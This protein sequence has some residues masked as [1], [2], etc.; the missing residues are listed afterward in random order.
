MAG[1]IFAEGEGAE[2]AYL[3]RVAG[4]IKVDGVRAAG[5]KGL[6]KIDEHRSCFT[7]VLKRG[8]TQEYLV[9][10]ERRVQIE[11]DAPAVFQHPEADAVLALE[12]LPFRVDADIEV[13]KEQV[14]VGAVRPVA[15]AQNV[16]PRRR[17]G[18]ECAER[19]E[20]S[21]ETSKSP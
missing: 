18:G 3:H 17:A 19:H 4:V 1:G 14:V 12:K 7:L 2:P 6:R 8:R 13:V 5:L 11:L 9:D 10:L 15:T 21:P 20:Q 16:G